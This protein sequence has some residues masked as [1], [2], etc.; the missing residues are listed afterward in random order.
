MRR[1]LLLLLMPFA[2]AAGALNS[3]A[4]ELGKHGFADSGGVKTHYVTKGEGPLL[5]MFGSD[6]SRTEGSGAVARG[7]ERHVAMAG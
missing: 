1:R 2:F 3:H 7:A 6:D 5:V 4:D